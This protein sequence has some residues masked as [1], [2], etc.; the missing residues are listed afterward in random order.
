M[1]K[2]KELLTMI[3]QTVP[4]ERND[5]LHVFK[6]FLAEIDEYRELIKQNEASLLKK[7]KELS[8]KDKLIEDLKKQLE[9]Q[10]S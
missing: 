2:T 4:E 3:N 10:K 8:A 5:E 7:D 9:Q 1:V 6:L